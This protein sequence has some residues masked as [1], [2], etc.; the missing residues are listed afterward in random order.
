MT[1]RSSG[2]IAG[3]LALVALLAGYALRFSRTE[4]GPRSETK[5]SGSPGSDVELAKAGLSEVTE[6]S[7]PVDAPA[8]S[9]LA[10]QRTIAA[11]ALGE[12]SNANRSAYVLNGT[13]LLSDGQGR[14]LPP[15]DGTLSLWLR[16]LVDS[17]TPRSLTTP[18]LQRRS[19]TAGAWSLEVADPQTRNRIWRVE[20]VVDDRNAVI[21]SE[22]HDLPLPL[23]RFLEI[24]AH[25]PPS[26]SLRVVDAGTG[27]DLSGVV[28][29]SV[30]RYGREDHSHPGLD[31][32]NRILA[33]DLDS[34][35]DLDNLLR[36]EQRAQRNAFFVGAAGYAWDC[37]TIDFPSGGERLVA[38]ER[39]GAV[40]VAL[41]D[42]DP[43][44]FIFLRMREASSA[45]LLYD[46]QLGR[47]DLVRVDGLPPG[48][49]KITAEIKLAR[50]G[51]LEATALAGA[52][53]EIVAGR[54]VSA[55]LEL[56]KVP[57]SE[58]LT[59]AGI[60]LVPAAWKCER[61]DVTALPLGE[62]QGVGQ[63]FAAVATKV[64]SPRAGFDAFEFSLERSVAGPYCLSTR[65]PPV[66]FVVDVPP[67]GRSDLVLELGPPCELAVHVVDAQT[68]APADRVFVFW[69]P[70]R[71]PG[72][73]AFAGDTKIADYDAALRTHT[74]RA[75]CG[76]V[77]VSITEFDWLPYQGSFDVAACAH[78]VTIELTRACSL[79]VKLRD[80]P[81]A[82]PLPREWKPT[83]VCTS[84]ASAR[85]EVAD[86]DPFAYRFQ[87]SE[88]GTYTCKLP[89]LAGFREPAEQTVEVPARGL[90]E[91]VV[92]LERER[93]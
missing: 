28:L 29:V 42:V 23:D 53:V 43:D 47:T 8:K 61:Q 32:E 51:A 16:G 30:S 86:A 35:I 50:G 75:P 93:R 92:Q 79:I 49:T 70:A 36:L 55:V 5:F 81:A 62:G 65:V 15:Q 45:R 66:S 77:D 2:W 84:S 68:R 87:L 27:R 76:V 31:F 64:E 37:V 39:G 13:V 59:L 18:T 52:E 20:L 12:S 85:A 91:C 24:S 41:R 69:N 56:S 11:D 58:H 14:L 54:T 26:S 72:A 57:E 21:D 1:R 22:I 67:Q 34:P 80:G 83:L 63:L 78:D 9:A 25:L 46:Q 74:L 73:P 38:L 40:E 89:K 19:V 82:V 17:T 4:T 60:V 10:E 3:V 7:T 88:P 48:R 33:Y 6:G 90:V 71:P 44:R